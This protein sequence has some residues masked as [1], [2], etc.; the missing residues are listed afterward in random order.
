[1]KVLLVGESWSQR[2]VNTVGLD[3]IEMGQYTE[4][5]DKFQ[6]G[7]RGMGIEVTYLPGHQ[8]SVYF[9][10]TLEE[11]QAYEVIIISDVGSNTLLLHPKVQ[12]QCIRIPNRLHVLTEYVKSG[13][14]LL[15]CG[16]YMGFSGFMGKAR[17]EMTPLAEILPVTLMGVDDRIEEPSGAAPRILVKDHPILKN[18]DGEWPFF[19]GYNKLHIK[20]EAIQ[21]ASIN[22]SDAF[23]AVRECGEGR[24]G[25]FASDIAPHWAPPEFTD[26]KG[27]PVFFSNY[28]SWLAHEDNE[29][30][31]GQI[32]D[33][34]LR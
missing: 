2:N 15:M 4:A 25:V 22:E 9:P 32:G 12:N 31:G 27:Y 11:M 28:I 13:G 30:T 17:Y 24:V 6:D 21:I 5:S 16:G 23:I 1:M 20:E 19:L 8:A 29:I 14:G 18:L 26:W 34:N 10:M 33:G 3:T 7:L